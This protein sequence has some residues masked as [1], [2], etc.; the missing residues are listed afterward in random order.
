MSRRFEFSASIARDGSLCAEERE[1]LDP[2]E[3]W[4]PEHLLLAAL[5]RCTLSSLRFHAER[6]G[7][8]ATGTAAATG[9]VAKRDS[10]GRHAFVE[11]L[12]GFD[13]NLE[14]PPEDAHDLL[15]LAER[16]CFI[17]ASLTVKPEYEWRVN[18]DIVT[19]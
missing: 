3:T 18:G 7:V 13:V 5:C 11:I 2:G 8:R 1:R 9:L 14:P 16:D 15:D 10:D 4:T 6:A 12:C 19:G 17:G